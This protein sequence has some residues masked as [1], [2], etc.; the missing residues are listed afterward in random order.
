MAA[1]SYGTTENFASLARAMNSVPS[2][3]PYVPLRGVR[4]V[5]TFR[6]RRGYRYHPRRR[7]LGVASRPPR[8]LKYLDCAW[9][10]VSVPGVSADATGLEFQPTTGC[11]DCISKPAQGVGALQ[12]NG[13]SYWIK[14]LFFSG[15][16]IHA[17]R[18]TLSN[19]DVFPQVFF[20]LVLDREPQGVTINSEDVYTNPATTGHGMIPPLRNLNNIERFIV[21]ASGYAK[22]RYGIAGVF[23]DAATTGTERFSHQ[24][25]TLSW[26]GS[27]LAHTNGSTASI[28]GVRSNALHIIAMAD[29]TAQPTFTGKS[30]MR[31]IG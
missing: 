28:V 15:V 27:I 5:R 17:A 13:N 18:N 11:T 19:P 26:R 8:E 7:M 21:L 31:F 23:N 29:Y 1:R 22:P 14:S 20:A 2:R 30:R 10:A 24:H 12:H 25:I 16:V 3:S 6:R 9:N 4:R